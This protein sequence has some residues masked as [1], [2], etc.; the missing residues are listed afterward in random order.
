MRASWRYK[1]SFVVVV[2]IVVVVRRSSFVNVVVV[3]V[4]VAAKSCR[5]QGRE[6]DACEEGRTDASTVV[7]GRKASGDVNADGE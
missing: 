7:E 4:V 3:N 6:T 2:A 5:R 1:K